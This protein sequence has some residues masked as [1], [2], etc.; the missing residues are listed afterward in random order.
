MSEQS[1]IE[2]LSNL[3]FNKFKTL[4]NDA[5]LSRYEK[6][7]FFN[8]FREGKELFIWSDIQSKVDTLSEIGARVLDIGPG[9]SDLPFMLLKNAEEKGQSVVFIDSQEM[10]NQLPDFDCCE[11]LPA[12]FP[13]ETVNWC[14]ENAESFNAIICYSVLHIIALESNVGLT[15]ECIC[16]LLAPGGYALI[17]DIP[18]VSKRNRFFSSSEGVAYHQKN[19]GPESFPEI[20]LKE[21]KRG[22]FDDS[23][24][25][26]II[27]LAR[28]KGV[29]A[30]LVPQNSQL[31]LAN[32]REDIVLIKYK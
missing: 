6:I 23:E 2:K 30:F 9:C 4:A 11:K 7:G 5:T 16:D 24:I 22:E 25:L 17:A 31:P 29:E 21:K 18:N 20:N 10:L 32:R 19:N 12:M 14:K 27:K 13:D 15:I 28:L 3:D 1:K 8:H 26:S